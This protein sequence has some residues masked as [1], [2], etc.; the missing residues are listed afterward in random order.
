[1]NRRQLHALAQQTMRQLGLTPPLDVNLLLERLGEQRERPI[2]LTPSTELTGQRH[3]GFTGDDPNEEATVIF[4]EPRTPWTHQIMIILHELAHL[5]CGHP[6]HAIDHSYRA[7]HAREFQEISPQ[8]LAEVL[9]DR[10][11]RWP[12]ARKVSAGIGRS[13]YDQPA[14]WE[15]ETMATIMIEWVPGCGGHI[16]PSPTDPLQA[17]LGDVPA[18]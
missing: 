1:M 6:G 17:I 12:R 10:P 4:Y 18:W 8:M 15:A 5:I 3:F 2:V 14:E 9:R 16:T 13:L 11:R 7:D